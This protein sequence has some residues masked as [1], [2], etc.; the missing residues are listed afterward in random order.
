M[1]TRWMSDNGKQV[2]GVSVVQAGIMTI[3]KTT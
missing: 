2:N 1:I 3:H